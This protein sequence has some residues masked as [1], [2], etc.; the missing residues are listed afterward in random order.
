MWVGA[1]DVNTPFIQVSWG[2][3]SLVSGQVLEGTTKPGMPGQPYVAQRGGDNSGLGA[4]LAETPTLVRVSYAVD[5]YGLPGPNG[6]GVVWVNGRRFFYNGE[7][8]ITYSEL[9]MFLGKVGEVSQP[10]VVRCDV[11]TDEVG[12][13]FDVVR[14]AQL[15][16]V[17]SSAPASAKV[18]PGRCP[19]LTVTPAGVATWTAPVPT[20][21]PITGFLLMLESDDD[22]LQFWVESVSAATRTFTFA[23]LEAGSDYTL[24]V[25]P[26]TDWGM[27]DMKVA[28]FTAA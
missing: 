5:F 8:T 20:A 24:Q 12:T 22:Q 19:T 14:D 13:G 4:F 2:D 23:G 28:S 6:S 1:V 17:L 26:V 10:T 16:P 27:P 9:V 25:C 3:Q 11:F 18:L 21:V 15:L 7:D